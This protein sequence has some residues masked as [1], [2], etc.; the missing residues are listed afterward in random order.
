MDPIREPAEPVVAID[1]LTDPKALECP[2]AAAITTIA[3][4][5]EHDA[6]VEY[7]SKGGHSKEFSKALLEVLRLRHTYQ[8]HEL[9]QFKCVAFVLDSADRDQPGHANEL[10]LDEQAVAAALEEGSVEKLGALG[11]P[12]AR[13]KFEV[14]LKPEQ[15]DTF[16]EAFAA[17]EARLTAFVKEHGPVLQLAFLGWQGPQGGWSEKMLQ[18]LVKVADAQGKWIYYETAAPAGGEEA[19]SFSKHGFQEMGEHPVGQGSGVP[20]LRVL[21]RPPGAA[22]EQ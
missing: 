14:L 10:Q 18:H 1:E 9:S 15:R 3:Q 5:L 8:I 17:A 2:T 16:W 11:M 13:A 4:A 20:V 21:A 6:A 7:F 12:Q 22:K 19:N